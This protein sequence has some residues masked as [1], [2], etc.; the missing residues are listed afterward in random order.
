VYT[1]LRHGD[2]DV[3]ALRHPLDEEL[4]AWVHRID[5]DACSG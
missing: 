5:L 2:L 4:A 3:A 1:A